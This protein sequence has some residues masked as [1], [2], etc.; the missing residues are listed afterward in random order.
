MR[1]DELQRRVRRAR[2]YNI[3]KI[4]VRDHARRCQKAR[5]N[6]WASINYYVSPNVPKSNQF[7]G[8]NIQ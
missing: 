3:D 5:S 7:A 1:W 6:E 4:S 8:S 2:V